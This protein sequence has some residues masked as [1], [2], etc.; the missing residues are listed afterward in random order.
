[1]PDSDGLE[2]FALIL[3]IAD[4]DQT[5]VERKRRLAAA[6]EIA[7]QVREAKKKPN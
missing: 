3:D 5:E 1:M 6:E 7:D 4:E 2:D